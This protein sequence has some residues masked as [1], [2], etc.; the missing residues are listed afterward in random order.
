MFL[1]RRYD[2]SCISILSVCFLTFRFRTE[3]NDFIKPNQD[4]DVFDLKK[5]PHITDE[6]DKKFH[7]FDLCKKK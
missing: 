2:A 7:G 3:E 6:S 5:D 4:Y 1:L